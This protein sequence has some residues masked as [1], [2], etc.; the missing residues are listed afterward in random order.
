[1]PHG[2]IWL[3]AGI[4]TVGVG[5]RRRHHAASRQYRS[6]RHDSTRCRPPSLCSGGASRY[7]LRGPPPDKKSTTNARGLKI[8]GRTVPGCGGRPAAAANP[9]PKTAIITLDLVE[10]SIDDVARPGRRQ[11][12]ALRSTPHASDVSVPQSA[13]MAAMMSASALCATSQPGAAGETPPRY[14]A[15]L[16][17][18]R[19]GSE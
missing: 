13:R 9:K 11:S 17:C 16:P 1:L 5:E 15:D 6:L 12:P 14:S 8:R 10:L 2:L 4:R 3:R 19:R 7:V 18:G